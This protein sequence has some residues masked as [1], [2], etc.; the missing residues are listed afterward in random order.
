LYFNSDGGI[1]HFGNIFDKSKLFGKSK[2]DAMRFI[3]GISNFNTSVCLKLIRREILYSD[4]GAVLFNENI[5]FAEDSDFSLKLF[6]YAGT[7]N[8]CD[9]YI[10]FY[11][12]ERKGSATYAYSEKKY[13]D[14]LHVISEWAEKAAANPDCADISEE[15]YEIL[16]FQYCLLLQGYGKIDSISRRKF[17]SATK[18]Y[19]WLLNKTKDGRVAMIKRFY[20]FFGLGP[21]CFALKI[22]GMFVKQ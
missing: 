6:M 15:I 10:Y 14:S 13:A 12:K 21:T 1:K 18:K 8:Y 22:R 16:A 9:S 19:A 2:K 4:P 17:K 7:Y 3:S 5:T 11:R 20:R